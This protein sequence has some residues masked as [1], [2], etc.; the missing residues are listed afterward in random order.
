MN[1][2]QRRFEKRCV[3]TRYSHTTTPKPQTGPSYQYPVPA[4]TRKPRPNPLFQPLEKFKKEGH[5]LCINTCT[6][7]GNESGQ[8]LEIAAAGGHDLHRG[9][10]RAALLARCWGCGPWHHARRLS[11]D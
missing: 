7:R 6:D 5:E 11:P 9:P 3:P 1:Y 8:R 2:I 4:Q 10:F